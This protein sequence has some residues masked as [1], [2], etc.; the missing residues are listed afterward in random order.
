MAALSPSMY[1][2]RATDWMM[3]SPK[4]APMCA[5]PRRK[6]GSSRLYLQMHTYTYDVS[7][8]TCTVVKMLMTAEKNPMPNTSHRRGTLL[9]T[10]GQGQGQ[11]RRVMEARWRHTRCE[12]L[13]LNEPVKTAQTQASSS[14]AGYPPS[15]RHTPHVTHPAYTTMVQTTGAAPMW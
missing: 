5:P 13:A 12:Q 14:Q 2:K 10:G 15:V 1:T 7:S 8:P 4:N 9:H 6:C 11:N 3:A